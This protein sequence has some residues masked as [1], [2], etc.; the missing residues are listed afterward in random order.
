MEW[1]GSAK[2]LTNEAQ[3]KKNVR[4]GLVGASDRKPRGNNEVKR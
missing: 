3:K 1:A 2:M 4:N